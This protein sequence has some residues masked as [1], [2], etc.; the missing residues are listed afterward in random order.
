MKIIKDQTSFNWVGSEQPFV[1]QLDIQQM[2]SV[3]IGRFGVMRRNR[4]AQPLKNI[5]S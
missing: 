3:T 2:G 4:C 5:W 1:D